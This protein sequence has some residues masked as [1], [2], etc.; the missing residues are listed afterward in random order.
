MLFFFSPP[1]RVIPVSECCRWLGHPRMWIQ[2]ELLH[3]DYWFWRFG[4]V[5]KVRQLP[6]QSSRF[7][8]GLPSCSQKR[9]EKGIRWILKMVKPCFFT[10]GNIAHCTNWELRI[11]LLL[12]EMTMCANL[13]LILW[14]WD[15]NTP[16]CL[17]QGWQYFCRRL[18][19]PSHRATAFRITERGRDHWGGEAAVRVCLLPG[20]Q[21]WAFRVFFCSLV[22]WSNWW[23]KIWRQYSVTQQH[24]ATPLRCLLLLRLFWFREY[25]VLRYE[26]AID[27]WVRVATSQH[28]F[29]K[30]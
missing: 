30:L 12:F 17:I 16:R 29:S 25:R 9:I 15:W 3:P 24:A 21:P 10:H 13:F 1:N 4:E 22:R 11:I 5:E 23:S 14:G 26:M 7:C 6:V 28:T 2:G 19:Q 8:H 18:R 27:V 20:S